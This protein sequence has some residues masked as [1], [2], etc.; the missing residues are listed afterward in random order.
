MAPFEPHKTYI[1]Q[2]RRDRDAST[3]QYSIP[4]GLTVAV[5]NGKLEPIAGKYAWP[6]GADAFPPG[7]AYADVRDTF[8]RVSRLKSCPESR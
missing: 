5:G 1:L 4:E 3:R 7:A 6:T 2:L 8:L